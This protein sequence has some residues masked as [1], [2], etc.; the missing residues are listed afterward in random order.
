MKSAAN[1][2]NGPL[3]RGRKLRQLRMRV[4]RSL[5]G[6]IEPFTTSRA[7]QLLMGEGDSARYEASIVESQMGDD[8]RQ[9]IWEAFGMRVNRETM[10][11]WIQTV[12]DTLGSEMQRILPSSSDLASYLWN[13]Y[14]EE[15]GY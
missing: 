13:K 12:Y 6:W 3:A 7:C 1:L 11:S 2:A 4:L 10:R 14:L 9:L 15:R 5:V 8:L